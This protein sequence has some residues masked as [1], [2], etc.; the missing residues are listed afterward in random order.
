MHAG[1]LRA[2]LLTIGLSYGACLTS[3]AQLLRCVN[4]G[5][6]QFLE[7]DAH[8]ACYEPWQQALFPALVALVAY[9]L[10][11]AAAGWR[12][13]RAPRHSLTPLR[14]VALAELGAPFHAGARWWDGVLL[15]RRLALVL[16][17]VFWPASGRTWSALVSAVLCVLFLVS[18]LAVRPYSAR[19][20][21]HAETCLLATLCVVSMRG[22]AD[23]VFLSTGTPLPPSFQ[24]AYRVWQTVVAAL[25]TA[26]LLAGIGLVAAHAA[27]RRADARK[28]SVSAA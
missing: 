7:V 2:S 26:P 5:G 21:H 28:R 13:G 3:V 24:G 15:L 25:V 16:I 10:A 27:R 9:P 1:L 23:A 11:V 14:R 22:V 20:A 12:L 4:I 19:W 18:H 6:R 17:Y 8:I